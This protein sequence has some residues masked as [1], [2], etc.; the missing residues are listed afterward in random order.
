M[1][2]I[3]LRIEDR[4]PWSFLGGLSFSI[5]SFTFGMNNNIALFSLLLLIIFD[6]I[7]AVAAAY[8]TGEEI[9]SAKILRSAVKIVV[10][11]GLVAGAHL[12]ENGLP[13][14]AGILDESTIGFL[15]ATELISLME[16]AGKL[17]FKTPNVVL[18][19]LKEFTD[20]KQ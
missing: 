8:V 13:L 12:A 9:K 17:G 11:F 2:D 6:F 14:F 15:V 16:N 1:F 3:L 20:R 10:Y 19:R 18:N 7:S 5:Y 4:M